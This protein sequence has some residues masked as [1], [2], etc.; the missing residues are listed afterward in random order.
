MAMLSSNSRHIVVE[1]ASRG[2]IVTDPKHVRVV[3]DATRLVLDAVAHGRSVE[4]RG[5]SA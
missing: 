1:G 4:A 2:T 3:A 5:A